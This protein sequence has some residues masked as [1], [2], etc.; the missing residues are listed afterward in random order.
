MSKEKK[1]IE[2]E[3][4]EL[5][6]PGKL[7]G[8]EV[9]DSLAR[10]VGVVRN[11]K[12]QFYPFNMFLIVKGIGI[13]FPISINDVEAISTVIRLKTPAKQSEEI[14][15]EDVLRLRQEIV[16]ELKLLNVNLK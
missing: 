4:Y 5:N 15:V 10:K 9:V 2:T 14:G 3:L 8:R 1:S 16:S 6:M 11:I 13:E 7:V 12:L